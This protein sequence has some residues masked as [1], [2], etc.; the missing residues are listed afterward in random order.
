MIPV[1]R[2]QKMI[3]QGFNPEQVYAVKRFN[4]HMWHLFLRWIWLGMLNRW[5]KQL[6]AHLKSRDDLDE[7]KTDEEEFEEMADYNEL[8]FELDLDD[9]DIS[10]E[11]KA[12]LQWDYKQF[13]SNL[14]ATDLELNLYRF[15]GT[16]AAV[17]TRTQWESMAFLTPKGLLTEIPQVFDANP[18]SFSMF[19]RLLGVGGELVNKDVYSKNPSASLEINRAYHAGDSKGIV[20]GLKL[21]PW[22]RFPFSWM[23]PDSYTKSYLFYRMVNAGLRQSK[24][25]TIFDKLNDALTSWSAMPSWIIPEPEDNTPVDYEEDESAL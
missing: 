11:E 19:F 16:Y 14:Y 7:K 2:K 10:K 12:K 9:A 21:M 24:D 20:H 5:I 4:T 6:L 3:K 13:L 22:L 1:N 18:L 25:A 23:D 17:E 8:E 15:L